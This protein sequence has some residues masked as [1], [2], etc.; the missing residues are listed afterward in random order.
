MCWNF[1]SPY[2]EFCENSSLFLIEKV[3]KNA[4]FQQ[5]NIRKSKK[6][7]NIVE[8]VTFKMQKIAWGVDFLTP[9][10]SCT[11]CLGSIVTINLCVPMR[12]KNIKK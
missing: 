6:F 3:A 2:S 5:K 1:V 7:L 8:N 10:S 9:R 12:T 11:M 4:D